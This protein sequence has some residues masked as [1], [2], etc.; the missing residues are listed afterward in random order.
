MSRRTDRG[1]DQDG[2]PPDAEYAERSATD[3]DAAE[4]PVLPLPEASAASAPD[5]ASLVGPVA[6]LTDK[7][8]RAKAELENVRR[9]SRLEAEQARRYGAAPVLVGLLS[10]LDNL[11]RALAAP[12]AALDAEYLAGLQLIERQFLDVL[13]THGVTPVPAARGMPL[14]PSMH[15]ALM[16]QESDE[17]APG[18]ILLVAVPGYRLHDRL[19]R[20]AQVVVARAPAPA[21]A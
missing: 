5:G 13:A 9:T 15:R 8:L 4:T 1:H 20:E 12:P 16:E 17:I 2:P 19:L 21:E 18:C 11:Q 3:G 6:E 14:D 7:W 10:V